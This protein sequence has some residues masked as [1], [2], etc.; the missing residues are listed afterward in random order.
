MILRR[1][2]QHV[3]QQNWTA[4]GI[5]FLIVVLGVFLGI[6][7][8][9]WNA[10]LSDRAAYGRALDRLDAEIETDLGILDA[11]DPDIAQTQRIVRAG[12]DALRSCVDSEANRRAIDAGLNEVRSSY[13][14]HLRRI[15][16]DELTTDPALLAQQSSAERQ[17]F[18]DMLFT[19]DL[20]QGTADFA[21]SYPLE[22]RVE[23]DPA[24][25]TGEP[26]DTTFTYFG[27]EFAKTNYPLRLVVPVD[28]ACR[29]GRL[30]AHFRAWL[31]WQGNLP[32]ASRAI[33]HELEQTRALLARREP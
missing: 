22:G 14:L 25:G 3:R 4:I 6:Q 26:R 16:L 33:R 5:D 29:A 10:A 12:F 27:A 9:N 19:F 7:L 11:L 2:A 15:A 13:G 28:E 18:A 30:D 8:G 17:R 32:V 20:M 21:E 23:A 24:V 1:I 31:A